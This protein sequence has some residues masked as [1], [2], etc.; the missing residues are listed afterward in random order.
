[1]VN[2]DRQID[3]VKATIEERRGAY[4]DPAKMFGQIAKRWG[5]RETEVA[6]RM[7]DLKLAR[8]THGSWSDDSAIDA[9]AYLLF[10]LEFDD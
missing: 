4:G 7:A 8:L 10:A 1:M 2:I 3:R 5:C 6:L 9:I